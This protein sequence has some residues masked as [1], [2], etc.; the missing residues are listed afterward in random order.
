MVASVGQVPEPEPAVQDDA[1]RLFDQARKRDALL[2]VSDDDLLAPYHKYVRDNHEAL[3]RILKRDWSIDLSLKDF[4]SNSGD[5]ADPLYSVNP[6]G[7][8]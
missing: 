7:C 3:C 2:C 8:V 5:D 1:K 6:L 4:C